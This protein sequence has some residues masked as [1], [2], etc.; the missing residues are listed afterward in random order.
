LAEFTLNNRFDP[1]KNMK[2]VVRWD[3]KIIPGVSKMSPLVRTTEVVKHR[4][5]GDPSSSRKS[6]GLTEFDPIILERG[7]THDPAFEEWVNQVWHLGSG[8][9]TEVSLADFRKEV[10]ID[11]LNEAGQLVKRYIV[12]RCWPSEYQAL[13]G[14]D[15]NNTEVAIEIIKLENEGWER[16]ISVAEPKEPSFNIE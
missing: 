13:P 16:D 15:A 11:V 1:Y 10:L 3:N 14:F 8:L 7:L 4:E 2:F 5:G 6:P 9:G 12:H